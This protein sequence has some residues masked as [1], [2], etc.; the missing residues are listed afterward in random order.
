MADSYSARIL[1]Q[2]NQEHPQ[3]AETKGAL[4]EKFRFGASSAGHGGGL[5]AMDDYIGLAS[6]SKV[7]LSTPTFLLRGNTSSTADGAQA[8][9]GSKGIARS[10]TLRS[11]AAKTTGGGSS[12]LTLL[13]ASAR[14][15]LWWWDALLRT[16]WPSRVFLLVTL[17]EAAIDISIESILLARFQ[18]QKDINAN[19]AEQRALP[20][21]LIVFGLAHVY[22]F[23]LAVDAVVNKNTILVIGMAIFNGCL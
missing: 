7:S 13:S 4:D 15:Y 12:H 10:K 23:F 19:V 21:W 16:S 5:Y 1:Q 6:S 14:P 9:A 17:L 3:H 2:Y 22:Q 11:H 18:N 8:Q 20:V